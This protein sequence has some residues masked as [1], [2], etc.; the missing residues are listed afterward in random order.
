M[1]TSTHTIIRIISS[2][3]VL[4]KLLIAATTAEWGVQVG[5]IYKC[6][7]LLTLV[8]CGTYSRDTLQ[9]LHNVTYNF[10]AIPALYIAHFIAVAFAGNPAIPLTFD[11]V[12]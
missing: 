3:R 7:G 11:T 8:V 12:R 2:P 9:T 6:A 1:I 10:P 4:Y 5:T